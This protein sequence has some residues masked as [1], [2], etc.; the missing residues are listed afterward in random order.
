MKNYIRPP[1]MEARGIYL[2]G[3]TAGNPGFPQKAPYL[4]QIGINSV[5][6]DVKDVGGTVNYRSSLPMVKKYNLSDKCPIDNVDLFIKSMK[7]QG[8]YT[9]ARIAVFRDHALIENPPQLAIKSKRSGGVWNRGSKEIWCDPTSRIVQDYNID[10]AL[11][12]ASKGAD[13]IQFDYIRFP[14]TGDL[15]DASFAYDYGKMEKEQAISD[16]LARAF[17]KISAAN[18]RLSIDIFGVVAW[19]KNVDIQK[20]GQRI[21]LLSQNCDYISPMLYPSHFENDFDGYANPADHPYYFINEGNRKVME[22]LANKKVV[23]R[24]WLQAFQWRVTSYSPQYIIKQIEGS[25]DS[26][27]SGYLFWNASNDYDKVF[28]AMEKIYG[29]KGKGNNTD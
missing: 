27:A 10:L 19:G 7:S 15:N 2:T 25:R 1:L 9:I 5:V 17:R 4:K 29:K 11:E 28:A 13:E 12:I 24:P 3:L 18:A 14:T 23:I 6:F 26:G 22:R 16:F 8:I 20:T 21:E